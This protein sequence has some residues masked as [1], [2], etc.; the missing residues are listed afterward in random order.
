MNSRS[1]SRKSGFKGDRFIPFRGIENH[2]VEEYQICNEIYN[3]ENSKKE[4]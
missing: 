1:N 3:K 4:I 2:F